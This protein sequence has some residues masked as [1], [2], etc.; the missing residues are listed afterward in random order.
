MALVLGRMLFSLIGVV[1]GFSIGRKYVASIIHRI[2]DIESSS[3]TAVA[4]ILLSIYVG[5]QIFRS[6]VYD[7][8]L[9]EKLLG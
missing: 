1:L 7:F 6:L 8:L 4:G 3:G 9:I 2:W 5:E